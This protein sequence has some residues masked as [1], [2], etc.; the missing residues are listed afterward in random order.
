MKVKEKEL[1]RRLRKEEGLSLGDI[2][3]KVGVAKSSVSLW[4]RDIGLTKDQEDKL[5]SQNPLYSRQ[6][7]ANNKWSKYN[8][9]N[10]YRCQKK[11]RK[12]VQNGCSDL[13]KMGCMLYWAEGSKYRNS[14]VFCNTDLNMLLLFKKFLQKEFNLQ[15]NSFTLCVHA[16]VSDTITIG[17]I[18]HYWVNSL[19]LDNSN[20]RKSVVNHSPSSSKG[21]RKNKHIYGC[22]RIQINKTDIVQ[23]IFGAIKEIAGIEDQKKWL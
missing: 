12:K 10:R 7:S 14:V 6:K 15:N 18:E 23:E 13:Y 1:A 5:K 17:E 21:F 20:L 8:L 2:A 19:S 11:G 22:C 3:K 16:Y 4:V 9:D